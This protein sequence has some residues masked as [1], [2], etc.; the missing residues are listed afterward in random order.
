MNK[1]IIK[2]LRIVKTSQILCTNK[3]KQSFKKIVKNRINKYKKKNTNF[4][5]VIKNARDD[6][7][8]RKKNTER[9]FS[10]NSANAIS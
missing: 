7:T 6:K 1:K 4:P 2:R 9:F 5:F 3:L 10:T 8:M